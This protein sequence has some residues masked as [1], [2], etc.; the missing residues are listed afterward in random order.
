MAVSKANPTGIGRIG[1]RIKVTGVPVP[2]RVHGRTMPSAPRMF[3]RWR[4][5]HS[6][7]ISDSEASHHSAG[8][9]HPRASTSRPPKEYSSQPGSAAVRRRREMSGIASHGMVGK[10]TGGIPL[11]SPSHEAGRRWIER[12]LLPA[13][14]SSRSRNPIGRPA[15]SSISLRDELTDRDKSTH[16]A[17]PHAT[18]TVVT[19][20]SSRYTRMRTPQR[21]TA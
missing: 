6:R 13:L 10:T 3:G 16:S 12:S 11:W 15:A 21:F 14:R 1:R 7:S 20:P 5:G 2:P 18:A 4:P 19:T 8:R 9:G 17:I